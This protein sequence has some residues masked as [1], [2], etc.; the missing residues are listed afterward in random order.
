MNNGRLV[1]IESQCQEKYLYEVRDD[2]GNLLA[3]N[4]L[5]KVL[6]KIEGLFAE[7]LRALEKKAFHKENYLTKC[8]LT[9][10]EK[11]FWKAYI[12]IQIM[13]RPEVIQATHDVLTEFLGDQ[14]SENNIHT[15]ALTQCLPFFSEIKPEDRSAFSVFL[16]PL[17]NMSIAIGV[18]ESGSLFTSDSPVYCYYSDRENLAEAKEYDKIILPLTPKLVMILF[19]GEA[20]RHYRNNRLIPADNEDLE[21]IKLSIAYAAQRWIYSQKELSE[22]DR[23][24]IEQ[25]RK[26][27]AEDETAQRG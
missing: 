10:E 18:D 8:I 23:T 2:D 21:E 12:A 5:E 4:W 17:L 20:A 13:R 7:N 22:T 3:P 24:I 16:Q 6:C 26:E 11:A 25:A 19:G 1:T 9:S 27:K 15:V 14:L